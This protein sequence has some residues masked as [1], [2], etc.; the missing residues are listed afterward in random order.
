MWV[1]AGGGHVSD[2]RLRR[3]ADWERCRRRRRRWDAGGPSSGG[4]REGGRGM[5]GEGEGRVFV[6]ERGGGVVGRGLRVGGG[7]VGEG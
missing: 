5:L 7:L 6:W 2:A 4:A 3:G 1:Q